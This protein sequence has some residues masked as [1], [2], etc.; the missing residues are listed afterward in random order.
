MADQTGSKGQWREPAGSASRA[1]PRTL[2]LYRRSNG[3]WGLFGPTDPVPADAVPGQVAEVAG[4][5]LGIA[6]GFGGKRLVGLGLEAH[7]RI[8]D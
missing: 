3:H 5:R 7:V 2:L 8:F 1:R 6:V 4:S